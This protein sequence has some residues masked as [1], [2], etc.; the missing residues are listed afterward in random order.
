MSSEWPA[1]RDRHKQLP[2]H[3]SEELWIKD[4]PDGALTVLSAPPHALV[5]DDFYQAVIAGRCHPDV[6]AGEGVFIIRA[7]NGTFRYAL[8]ALADDERTWHANRI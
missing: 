1:Y 7:T 4:E 6:S 5:D 2:P 8:D 3:T